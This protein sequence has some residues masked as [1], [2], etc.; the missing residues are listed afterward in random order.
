VRT[1]EGSQGNKG[2][3]GSKGSYGNNFLNS[4][5]ENKR[6]TTIFNVQFSIFKEFSKTNIQY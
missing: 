2:S 3:Q 5:T 4:R 6:L 1:I